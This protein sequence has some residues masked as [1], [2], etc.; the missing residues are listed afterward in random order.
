LTVRD[1]S[2][3]APTQAVLAAEVGQMELAYD[4]LGEVALLDLNDLQHNVRDGVHL[5]ALASI[6]TVLVAGFGGL[7][8]Q[9]GALCFAPRLPAE[10]KRLA[11]N[12]TLRGIYLRVEVLAAH[13]TY[14]L[15]AGKPVTVHHHGEEIALA[16]DKLVTCPIPTIETGPRPAQPPGRAPGVA[17]RRTRTAAGVADVDG[18]ADAELSSRPGGDSRAN[19]GAGG[20]A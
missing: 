14:R 17:W 11:F 3:S 1:S 19:S 2:L 16:V 12:V 10:I 18:P 20:V 9:Q 6:W 13:A 8:V 5:A 7:R 15:I 4:Y